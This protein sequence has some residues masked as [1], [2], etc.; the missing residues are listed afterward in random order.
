MVDYSLVRLDCPSVSFFFARLCGLLESVG[1]SRPQV[2]R[3]IGR[4]YPFR[5]ALVFLFSLVHCLICIA[6]T[7]SMSEEKEVTSSELEMGLSLS[8][9]RKALEADFI[10]GL[11]FPIHPLIKELFFHLQ[12][13]PA[14][15][16]PNS[17]RIVV[18]CSTHPRLK[19]QYHNRLERVRGYLETI[20][21]FD[22]LISP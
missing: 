4:D 20:T 1:R 14:Q 12:F 8:E 11:R 18:Y 5:L 3:F 15:L 13:A 22:M 2:R 21:D 6:Q 10:A 19:K 9:D 17:W 16:V 7:L